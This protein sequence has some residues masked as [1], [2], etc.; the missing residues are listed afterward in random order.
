[1]SVTGRGGQ[2]KNVRDP[3]TGKVRQVDRDPEEHEKWVRQFPH[4]RLIDDETFGKAQEILQANRG[5]V[6]GCRKKDGK[7]NG[8]KPGA[9]KCQPNREIQDLVFLKC[10]DTPD[11]TLF[12]PTR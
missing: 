9:S 3:L 4:L 6:T 1:M 12:H 8:S 5:A 2:K 11:G 10:T 7:L